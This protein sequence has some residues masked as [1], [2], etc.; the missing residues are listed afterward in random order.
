VYDIDN[1]KKNVPGG[2]P[3]GKKIVGDKVSY[4]N[5]A[6]VMWGGAFGQVEFKKNKWSSFVSA[7]LSKTGC[8]RIDYF[9]KKDLVLPD[10]TISQALA[11]G[12]TY[13]YNGVTYTHDSPEAKIPTSKREVFTGYTFK[14]G[15]NYNINDHQ[16]VFVNLGFLNM[17]PRMNFVFDNSNKKF[18]DIENQ[19]VS[20]IEAGYGFHHKKFAAN[21]NLYYTLWKNKPPSY[22]PTY[23]D[24]STGQT[25]SY[26]I[27]GLDALHKGIELDFIY[28]VLKNL[29]V[30]GIV[31][32]G[33]WKTMSNEKVYITRED[34]TVL[35]TIDFSAKN[36]H[37]GDAAQTQI[38]GS[39]RYEVV[40][41]LYIKPRFTYF[42]RNY[43][44]FDPVLL[45]GINKDRESWKMPNYGLLDIYAGYGFDYW[46]LK[47]DISAGIMNV[48]N[49]TYITDAQNGAKF[50]PTTAT[51]FVGMGRRFNIGLKISF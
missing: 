46:K 28:K 5:D 37:V 1:S 51:V 9:R 36:V 24:A 7:T 23:F 18:L 17:A 34:G 14:G 27:N 40:K 26:N 21:L 31:S 2:A 19:E 4:Y 30:E 48:L 16:N 15:A 8:Q 39:V 13:T 50:D 45:Q 44:N 29:D 25:Y 20:A 47:F 12:S 32:I 35:Q 41:N 11:Y 49:A 38:G 43:A 42:A 10:T 22:V 6:I 3:Y 33:D